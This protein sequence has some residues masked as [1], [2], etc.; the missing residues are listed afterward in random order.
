MGQEERRPLVSII[1]LTRNAVAYTKECIHSILKNT[2]ENIEFIFVDNGST[3]ETIAYL[4]SIPNGKVILNNENKGFAKGCNQGLAEAKG[5]FIIL[6]NN[7]TVVTKNWLTRLLWWLKVD[8][9]IGIV[10]PK[11]NVVLEPQRINN[12]PYNTILEMER[13]AKKIMEANRGTGMETEII[14]GLCMVFRKELI[15]QIGGLDERFS[16]G[17]YEDDDF[18]IRTMISGK[19]LWV[20]NDVYIHHYGNKSFKENTEDYEQI[21]R[22][23]LQKFIDKWNYSNYNSK[24]QLVEAEKPFNPERHFIPLK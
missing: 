24:K 6:L 11:S 13:F 20:A 10:G 8:Q 21:L 9:S 18:S 14:S 1:M 17:N 3:D 23:N 22:N 12:V 4:Q 19:R 2:K 15:Q 7:D 16:P 5:D